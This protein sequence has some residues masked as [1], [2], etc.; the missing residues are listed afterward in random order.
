MRFPFR[1][2]DQIQIWASSVIDLRSDTFTLPT[3]EM[4]QA[5]L[6]APLGN[7]GYGEDP[8]VNRLEA[9]ASAKLGKEASCFMPSGT[10]A[11]LACLLAHC[12][13]PSKAKTILVGDRSDLFAYEDASLAA[14]AGLRLH[15][16]HTNADGTM[17]LEEI[18][19]LLRTKEFGQIGL[20]CIEN[21]H[22]LCGGVVVPAG[23]MQE[24]CDVA[25]SHGAPVHLDGARIFNAAVKMQMSPAELTRF[26]DSVQFCLSKG[27]SAPAGSVVA[28]SA[29]FI[30]EVRE[31]RRILGG[32][33]R[34]AGVIA[35]PGIVAL[36]HMVDRLAVDH[37]LAQ[38]LA[39]GLSALPGIS[40]DLETVQTNTVVFCVDEDR[41][42]PEAFV[43]AAWARDLRLADFKYGRLRAVVHHGIAASDIDAAIEIFAELLR[44]PITSPS[45]ECAP[46][47]VSS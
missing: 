40:V 24:T 20:L 8:T 39:K 4:L 47:D 41:F 14:Q 11:N 30:A 29:N 27:L 16:L 33:M 2:H 28:G 18:R 9:L 26:A 31:K 13:S 6:E 23:W 19:A 10:M 45:T 42:T 37:E 1:L 32:A 35:A 44:E 22:N 38:R 43:Q 5:I 7:D 12:S 3:A 17:S 15:P 21:P 34:Q 25:Y 46:A 36:E